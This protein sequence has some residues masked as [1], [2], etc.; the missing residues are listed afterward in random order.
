VS[1]HHPPAP[2]PALPK[3]PKRKVTGAPFKLNRQFVEWCRTIHIYL[4]MLG[5]LVLLLFGITGFTV[6]HED[7]FGA[8]TPRVHD[9]EGKIPADLLA[10]GDSLHIVERLRQDFHI[11]GAMTSYDDLGDSIEVAFK[12]PGQLWNV[13]INKAAGDAKIH[14]EAFNFIAVIDNLHRGRYTGP[15]WHWVID[16]SALLI[17]VACFTGVVLW[18]TL[19]K[20]RKL[21]LAAVALGVL[22]TL[23]IYI[24]LVPGSDE[25][26]PPAADL[27]PATSAPA[28]PQP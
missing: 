17:V 8:T 18:L 15:A 25:P 19:P 26:P 12:D 1:S 2:K 13:E 21:G 22:G 23:I 14:V 10:R 11:T 5:L 3:P 16:I 28:T 20:R 7:W 9:S 27:S 4:T 24:M 6:N